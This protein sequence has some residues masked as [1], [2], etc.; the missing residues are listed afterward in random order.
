[1]KN[2][3]ERNLKELTLDYMI[4]CRRIEFYKR[5][6]D[7]NKVAEYVPAE[8]L[9]YDE[10]DLSEEQEFSNEIER[11][12]KHIVKDVKVESICFN[13]YE[14][15]IVYPFEGEEL[16][17]T[18]D[19]IVEGIKAYLK[20]V[21]YRKPDYKINQTRLAKY[22]EIKLGHEDAYGDIGTTCKEFLMSAIIEI[23][24]NNVLEN[25]EFR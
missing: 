7:I 23:I 2:N 13:N 15:I 22:W 25:G 10:I 19:K 6:I 8:D 20:N 1:M 5:E 24:K 4:K 16:F 9:C 11:L 12:L 3:K 14:G 18:N 17:I 21:G